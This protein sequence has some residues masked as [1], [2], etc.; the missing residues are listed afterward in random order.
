MATNVSQYLSS[1][2]NNIFLILLI[3]MPTTACHVMLVSFPAF[4]QSESFVINKLVVYV[5]IIII[6]NC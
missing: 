2:V 1:H 4:D 3:K 5:I 6:I